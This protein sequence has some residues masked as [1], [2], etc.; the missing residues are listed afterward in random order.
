VKDSRIGSGDVDM[1]VPESTALRLVAVR[2]TGEAV[3][4]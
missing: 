2:G 4:W 1:K 3:V